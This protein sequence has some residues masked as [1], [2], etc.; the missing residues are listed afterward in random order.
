MTR[1]KGRIVVLRPEPGAS[2]TVRRARDLGLDAVAMPLFE[3]EPIAWKSPDA[4]RF[5]AL[6]LTSA[7]AVR[8]GGEGLAALRGLPVHAVGEAT[9]QEAR[10]SGFDIASVGRSG[11]DALLATIDPAVKL[12]HLCG[13]ARTPPSGGGHSIT[14]IPV[15]RSRSMPAPDRLG[16]ANDLLLIHSPRAGARVA[17]LDLDRGSIALAAISPAAAAAAGEGWAAVEAAEQPADDALLALAKRMCNN[18][19]RP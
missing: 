16:R 8:H 17:E 14:A 1:P 4:A 18:L 9:A 19:G 12:L 3:V 6:L 13:E 10:R 2:E 11:V 5:D 7:N 15:Y